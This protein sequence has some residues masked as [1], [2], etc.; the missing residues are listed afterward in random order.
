LSIKPMRVTSTLG[1]PLSDRTAIGV[2]NNSVWTESEV[3]ASERQQH[4]HS[5]R[6]ERQSALATKN[7]DIRD[8]ASCSTS[9]LLFKNT[10]DNGGVKA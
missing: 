2:G 10:E 1:L 6:L 9:K 3:Q 4:G 5:E 8:K 7:Y